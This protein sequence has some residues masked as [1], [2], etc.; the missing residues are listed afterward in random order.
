MKAEIFE[1]IVKARLNH[2]EKLLCAKGVEYARNGDR[3]HNF[4]TAARIDD[5]SKFQALKGMWMKHIV[6][7]FDMIEDANNE[8]LPSQKLMD[9]KLSD[10]INYTL[11][12]EGLLREDIKETPI[13]FKC[14]T[15]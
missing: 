4:K 7:V 2:C 8:K 13:E 11:L 1:N 9:D 5:C 6:S 14:V 10:M 12:L 3:L 15:L